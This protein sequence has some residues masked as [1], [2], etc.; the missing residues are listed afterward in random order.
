[1]HTMP[2]FHPLWFP[3]SILVSTPHP[4]PP[5]LTEDAKNLAFHCTLPLIMAN[6]LEYQFFKFFKEYWE[7]CS[8]KN[9]KC[10]KMS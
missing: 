8:P 1:M 7:I 9:S 2:R 6:F 10:A 5:P 4:H 3:T